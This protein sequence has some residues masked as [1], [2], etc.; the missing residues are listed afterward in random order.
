MVVVVEDGWSMACQVARESEVS[1][2]AVEVIVFLVV[3]LGLYGGLLWRARRRQGKQH[4]H[5]D[6]WR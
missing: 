3:L 1:M 5:D 2:T 6:A 4:W